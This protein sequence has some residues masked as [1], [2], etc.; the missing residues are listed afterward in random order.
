MKKILTSKLRYKIYLS[1]RKYNEELVNRVID[2]Q[3]RTDKWNEVIKKLCEYT[4]KEKIPKEGN[5]LILV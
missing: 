1:V 3:I 4:S 5:Y 2:E